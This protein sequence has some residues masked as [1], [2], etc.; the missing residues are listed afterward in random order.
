MYTIVRNIVSSQKLF[1]GGGAGG[2][3][4]VKVALCPTYGEAECY[5][6]LTLTYDGLGG[7]D[8]A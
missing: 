3:R 4:T 6:E 8:E 7:S 2:Q 5:L 1:P